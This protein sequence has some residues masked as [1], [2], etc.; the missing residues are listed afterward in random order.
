MARELHLTYPAD[1]A[2]LYALIRQV[3]T[4][5]VWDAAGA[6]WAAWANADIDD[7]DIPLTDRGGHY[8]DATFPSGIATGTELHIQIRLQDGGSPDRDADAVVSR[9]NA[10]WDGTR[11][12]DP[13][14]GNLATMHTR[15][16]TLVGAGTVSAA[17][18]T[19]TET[20]IDWY[21]GDTDEL[22]FDCGYDLTSAALV[23]SVRTA[24]D[25]AAGTTDDPLIEKT[26]AA[27]AISIT[28]AGEG[29]FTLSLAATDTDELCE[30]GVPAHYQYDIQATFSDGDIRTLYRGQFTVHPDVTF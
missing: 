10:I 17:D 22:T 7:Y 9:I 20:D 3:S 26:S 19:D 8:Y 29:Q 28:D 27:G 11:L 24:A 21:R 4:G 5:K 12:V 15:L 1:S 6:A 30:T 25:L 14:S 13:G 18:I 2:T 16:Q 23:F